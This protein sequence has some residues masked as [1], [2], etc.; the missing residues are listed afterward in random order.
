MVAAPPMERAGRDACRD[1]VADHLLGA[2]AQPDDLVAVVGG[3]GTELVLDDA[4]ELVVAGVPGAV[5]VDQGSHPR[6]RGGLL[7]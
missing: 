6:H 5:V 4:S 3:E 2:A 7:R 1:L